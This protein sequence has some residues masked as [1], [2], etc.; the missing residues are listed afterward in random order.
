MCAFFHRRLHG[1]RTVTL[2]CNGKSDLKGIQ[3]WG[4]LWSLY[5]SGQLMWYETAVPFLS[6]IRSQC[7]TE[8]GGC[9][10]SIP[11]LKILTL[12]FTPDCGPKIMYYSYMSPS[13]RSDHQVSLNRSAVLQCF[14]VAFHFPVVAWR[15]CYLQVSP[16]PAVSRTFL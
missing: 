15:A 6:D 3:D 7:P 10:C 4:R 11:G 8:T 13:I 1:I 14:F 5:V 9:S 16:G 12:P 2:Y